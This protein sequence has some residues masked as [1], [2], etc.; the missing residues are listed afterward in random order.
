M[1]IGTTQSQDQSQSLIASV[2][3]TKTHFEKQ[4]NSKISEIE[5]SK[6]SYI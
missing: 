5:Q 4:N 3:I 1:Q 6:K 2:S